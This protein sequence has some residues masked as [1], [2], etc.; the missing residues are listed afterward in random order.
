M[1]NTAPP[2]ARPGTSAVTA[3]LLCCSLLLAAAAVVVGLA[4]QARAE[5]ELGELTFTT[6]SGKIADNPTFPKVGT[7]AAC[8]VDFAAQLQV[9]VVVPSGGTALLGRTTMRRALRP[10]PRDGRRAH[11][12]VAGGPAEGGDSRGIARRNVRDPALLP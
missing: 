11:G 1:R 6:A 12:H 8:P 10:G 9:S 3:L 4:P 7:D 5:G 2:N